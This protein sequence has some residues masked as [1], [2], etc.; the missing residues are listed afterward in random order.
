MDKLVVL[1]LLTALEGHVRAD[2]DGRVRRRRRDKLSQSYRTIEKSGKFFKGRIP[3]EMLFDAWKQHHTTCKIDVGRIKG[4][5]HFRNWL[6][7]GRWWVFKKGPMPV[8][9]NVK[10]S[11]EGVLHCLGIPFS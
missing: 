5:W 1:D 11:V 6:A 8:V 4:L 7:H 3:F 2:F 9:S 10:I